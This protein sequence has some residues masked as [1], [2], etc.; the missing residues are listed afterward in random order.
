MATAPVSPGG[1]GGNVRLEQPWFLP[2][3]G[4]FW[5]AP[6]RRYLTASIGVF[7]AAVLAVTL[8]PDPSA[9]AQPVEPD[10]LPSGTQPFTL[11]PDAE[12]GGELVA[13]D[14][15]GAVVQSRATGRRVEVLSLRSETSRTWVNPDGTRTT[16]EAAGP[17]RFVDAA[18]VWQDIDLDLDVTDPAG[19]GADG[20]DSVVAPG[21]HPLGLELPAGD[22]PTAPEAGDVSVVVG[23]TAPQA[24]VQVQPLAPITEA[25]GERVELGW[26][27]TLPEP[28]LDGPTATY[29]DVTTGVDLLVQATTV[30]YE[31]FMVLDE[32][33]TAD[34]A[35]SW[36]LPLT[37]NGAAPV[38][39]A[40]GSIAFVS[41]GE[42]ED[43]TPAG[44]VVSVLPAAHAWDAQL[45]PAGQVP[46]NYSAVDLSVTT[47]EGGL[48]AVT[49][50]PDPVWLQD[51]A[52][53]FPVTVDPSYASSSVTASSDT[54]VQSDTGS[55]VHGGKDELRVGTYNGGAA[56]ARSY[57]GINITGLRTKQI[58]SAELSLQ[59]TYSYSCTAR[60]WEAWS[61][62][63]FNE[64]STV[65]SNKPAFATRYGTS[66][67]TKGYASSCA[68]GRVKV[69][70]TD[71]V[72]WWQ[73]DTVN[74][75]K[76]IGLKAASETDSL[77]WKKF[78]SRETTTPPL[79]TYTY[80]RAPVAPAPA[81]TGGV[82]YPGTATPYLPTRTPVLTAKPTDPDANTVK[83]DFQVHTSMDGTSASLAAFCSSAYVASGTT[84]SCTSPQLADNIRYY[85]RARTVDQ[86]TATSVWSGWYSYVVTTTAPANPTITCPD[87]PT[88]SWTTT[89]PAAN[90]SCTVTGAGSGQSSPGWIRYKIDGGIEQKALIT[91]SS[92]TAT[93]KI[94]V[95]VPRTPNGRHTLEARTESRSAR[96]SSWVTWQAGWGTDV[97]M[98]SPIPGAAGNG[99]AT[100]TTD[101][102]AI[103]ASAPP[104]T[105]QTVAPTAKVQ[106]RVAGNPTAAWNDAG[107]AASLNAITGG[108][109]TTAARVTG[110]LATAQLTNDSANGIVLN[111]RV[112]VALQVRVCF[113]YGA[114]VNC[115]DTGGD[116]TRVPHAFGNGYPVAEAGPGQVAL[117]TG[118]FSTS[119][120]DISVPGYTGDL[121]IARTHATYADAGSSAAAVTGAFG[122]GWTANFDG[123]DAGV[124]G[125]EL[126]DST[127]YDGTLVLFTEDDTPLM[128]RN[129]GTRRTSA[130]FPTTTWAPVDEDTRA[131]GAVLK[132]VAAGS[133]TATARATVTL[134]DGTVTTFETQAVVTTGEAQWAPVAVTEPGVIGAT[135][136]TRDAQGR[137]TRILAP[138]PP[139]VTCPAPPAALVAGCRAL[140]IT[141]ATTTSGTAT[142]D[143]TGQIKTVSANLW[144]PTTSTVAPVPVAQYTYDTASKRLLTVTD[145]RTGLATQYSYHGTSTRLASVTP[146][147]LTPIQLQYAAASESGKGGGEF[148]FARAL[149]ARPA[150]DPAGGSATLANVV[151]NVPVTGTAATDKGL[152]DLSDA[153]GKLQQ[154]RTPTTGYAVFGPDAPAAALTTTTGAALTAEQWRYG[155]LQYADVEGYTVNAASYGAG[156]WQVSATDYD[157]TGNVIMTLDERAT[158]AVLADAPDGTGGDVGTT[159]PRQLATLTFYDA[160][161]ILVTDTLGPARAA[162][163]PD[164]STA[165]TREWTHTDYD[166]GA[167]TALN[168][169]TGLPW[170]LPT[171]ETSLAI[172]GA[173]STLTGDG[174]ATATH[175]TPR[176]VTGDPVLSRALTNYGT[177]E[178]SWTLGL[179]TSATTDVDG[180]GTV[181][182]GDITTTT[183]YDAEGKTVAT[184]LP[185]AAASPTSTDP[186][187]S[188]SRYYTAPTNSQDPCAG[189]PQWAGLECSTGPAGQPAGA[190]PTLPGTRTT[191][192]NIW[193]QP[194]TVVET[195]SSNSAGTGAGTT[196]VTRTSTTT[197][198]S[199]G[200]TIGAH[201]TTDSLTGNVPA[202]GSTTTYAPTTGLALSTTETTPGTFT[203][204]GRSTST[205]YDAWGRALTYTGDD[206][207]TTTTRYD[208]AGRVA[209]VTVP[210]GGGTAGVT[211]NHVTSYTY[212][213]TDSL[214]REERRGLTT[215]VS[216]TGLATQTGAYD[217]NGEIEHEKLPG[218]M[219]RTRTYDTAGEPLE[220]VYHGPI[221]FR[222]PASGALTPPEMAP[223]IGWSQANDV[224]GRVRA[225]WTPD[226]LSLDA[227]TGAAGELPVTG[228]AT[229]YARVYSYDRAER[230]TR[231]LDF[232][233]TDAGGVSPPTAEDG[234]P[235]AAE[236]T[237][238]CVARTYEFDTRGQRKKL[239]STAGPTTG[240][241]AGTCPDTTGTPVGWTRSATYDT[242]DR[243]L[244]GTS[245]QT[246]TTATGSYTYDALGRQ[247]SIPA[248][249]T[250]A[251]T[252]G[253][254]TAGPIQVSYDGN[255][256][257]RTIS[258]ATTVRTGTTPEGNPIT[259]RVLEA[260]QLTLDSMGRRQAETV[261]ST[262][263]DSGGNPTGAA[264]TIS[265]LVRHYGDTSDNPV[266]SFTDNPARDGKPAT[267]ERAVTG[268]GI[269]G[270][271]ATV[272]SSL[273][274]ALTGVSLNVAD[275]HGDITT[276][277]PLTPTTTVGVGLGPAASSITTWTHADE[278]GNPLANPTSGGVHVAKTIAARTGAATSTGPAYGWLGTHERALTTTGLTLMGARLYN[279]VV[280]NFTSVDPVAGGN[281]TAYAYP[282]DPVNETDLDGK[283][284]TK[285]KW[286]QRAAR[287]S[288]RQYVRAGGWGHRTLQRASGAK[289]R[290]WTS[291]GTMKICTGARGLGGLY[292]RRGGTMYGDTFVTNRRW[293]DVRGNN[294]L[295]RHEYTHVRQ[296]RR[297][298]ASYGARY[299]WAQRRGTCN[300]RYERQAGF[301][302]GGYTRCG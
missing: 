121:S 237:L 279:P 290:R 215:A 94:T 17:V 225:E 147:G 260:T 114:A 23:G 229:G 227:P 235:A 67:E 191:G 293:A 266:W 302:N 209:S 213:G 56:V 187:V 137:I 210:V 150:G 10:A 85:L 226:G 136:F 98:T 202:T 257:A 283:R 81:M 278:Y 48:S 70:V 144:N 69:P 30:G 138:A 112:P 129:T 83:V 82:I 32:R 97:T 31:T 153:A 211:S 42:V 301:K 36:S 54:Y 212:D 256:T 146:A 119:A 300:N 242:A 264:S 122:P 275:L 297:Y 250:P 93:S 206:G 298:G 29:A 99:A 201:V 170:R 156:A 66:T 92:S 280:A 61:A 142:G 91:P 113:T 139:G 243:P 157:P 291:R 247:L 195:S 143:V 268:D 6:G 39:Q 59:A 34:A 282:Q 186:A 116:V 199:S 120:T 274:G 261:T 49:V 296:W 145:P 263:L 127:T 173:I 251:F 131:S 95:A 123:P 272:T 179:A 177:T 221:T 151:Y 71:M 108:T 111:A 269:G 299:M 53:Q 118:E 277:I 284:R 25:S 167:P 223:W 190:L 20:R 133:S 244:T 79:L 65:W 68:G 228:Q 148:R 88:G 248:V 270:Y 214:G 181:T 287:W 5:C 19:G 200:R 75:V 174:S 182:T 130:A 220:A 219:E 265:N 77:G 207:L 72:T 232:T 1:F 126:I 197:Y 240:T 12:T 73:T 46:T 13:D 253:D 14:E 35:L 86:V 33:P 28:V 74:A 160:A 125:D 241:T 78:A 194:T 18:G 189:K 52:T 246:G 84:A 11:G 104:F 101:G 254:T 180:S 252:A 165:W 117:W 22:A 38:E 168:P 9:A 110:R 103:D 192:Y 159:D 262:S 285:K 21:A 149:R 161:G 286:Y 24:S 80:N 295:R 43:G 166:Q 26:P 163:R 288:N 271:T 3:A 236:E 7:T 183:V 176:T 37:V 276:T 155:S 233:R 16:E 2:D 267:Q 273:T 171:T 134:E 231:V 162:V 90:L 249:D 60:A 164:G 140:D 188:L 204:T 124:A 45:D 198:D 141:Y 239:T 132:V 172:D 50:T 128:W 154:Q 185:G 158:R 15:I 135:S 258:Q 224:E 294:R 230:L 259:A 47:L 106:W 193:L 205:S 281:T 234:T 208:A 57:I 238:P 217:A 58:M 44:E 203:S 89:A 102:V 255:D 175:P 62:G 4:R 100:V 105:S 96:M 87:Y 218:R 292:A 152:L 245:N 115:A 216:V 222:D 169:A 8:V 27:G 64:T 51:P 107:A 196:A 109:T 76:F 41:T 63:G 178:A 55:I 289:C 40:D 184:G